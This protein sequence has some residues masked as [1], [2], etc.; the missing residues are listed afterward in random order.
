MDE[1]L[2]NPLE[3]PKTFEGLLPWIINTF[4]P[5]FTKGKDYDNWRKVAKGFDARMEEL[6]NER[7]EL[8][9][10]LRKAVGRENLG[11]FIDDWNTNKEG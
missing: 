4:N 9:A 8:A 1:E 5:N 2:F 3:M 11:A 7:N 6:F 10:M